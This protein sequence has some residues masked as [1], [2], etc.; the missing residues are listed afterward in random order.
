ME[1]N[2][3][4][5]NSN[6]ELRVEETAKEH[7]KTAAKWAKFLAIFGFVMI[8][9]CISIMLVAAIVASTASSIGAL[10]LYIAAACIYV[11]PLYYL[12]QF[13]ITTQET[14]RSNNSDDLTDAL[15][16][17]KSVFKFC[18]IM[19]IVITALYAIIIIFAL[20]FWGISY[21]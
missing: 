4:T 15:S 19:T 1:N 17:L 12:Y 7:L 18:G 20:L 13:A 21:F 10:L 2:M 9:I 8:G 5:E 14:L 6:G 3:I 11:I 16:H